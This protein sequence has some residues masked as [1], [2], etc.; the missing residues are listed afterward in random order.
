MASAERESIAGVVRWWIFLWGQSQN[1]RAPVRGRGVRTP[2]KGPE[3]TSLF[4]HE[5]VAAHFKK[6]QKQKRDTGW[7]VV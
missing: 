7:T 5:M 6:A 1:A 4:H 2:G 3:H